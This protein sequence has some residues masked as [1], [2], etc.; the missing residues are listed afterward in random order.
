KEGFYKFSLIPYLKLRATYGYS[1]NVDP[2]MSAV[3]TIQYEDN[4]PYTTFPMSKVFN[5]FNPELRWEKVGMLNI[6]IDFRTTN[7]AF[8]GNIDYYL[9]KGTDL[10]G[11]IPIDYTAGLGTEFVT[12]NVASL[13]GSGLDIQLEA[14]IIK[15]KLFYWTTVFNLN[16]YS[17]KVLSYYQSLDIGGRYVTGSG[18]ISITPLERKP[19][20]AMLSYPWAGLNH[21]TGDPQGYLHKEKSVDFFSL[22]GSG[23]KAA[24]LI[25]SGHIMPTLSGSLG[26]AFSFKGFSL[27]AR[28][29]YKFNCYFRKSSIDY[30]SLFNGYASHSDFT[31]RWKSPGDEIQIDIPSMTYPASHS[32]DL[33]YMG[34]ETLVRRGDHIRLQYVNFSY[35]I[36]SRWLVRAHINNLR[37]YA[38]LNN[39]GIIWR[40]NVERVDP[41]FSDNAILM[42]KT[43]SLGGQVV[44]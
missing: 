35:E 7:N 16:Y 17:D 27:S 13:K 42:S 9:K 1:G 44:F 34:S 10:Y 18:L 37:L 31:K 2:S 12:K 41:D 24:D 3:T 5:F 21:E 26:N 33:F 8:S 22:T 25:Y 43:F 36:K 39:I 29:T 20:Y 6:G 15:T 38:N 23:T 30:A 32:R 19:V 40:K 4:N 11:T 14:S 28:F